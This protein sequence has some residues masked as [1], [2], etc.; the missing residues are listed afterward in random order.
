MPIELPE[1]VSDLRTKIARASLTN[2]FRQ[3]LS[4]DPPDYIMNNAGQIR[5]AERE[6]HEHYAPQIR[7]L[8]QASRSALRCVE[9]PGHEAAVTSFTSSVLTQPELDK[10]MRANLYLEELV[11]GTLRNGDSF[12][13]LLTLFVQLGQ[14]DD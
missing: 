7:L 5:R 13:T 14:L 9:G 3:A 11:V 2:F 8:A 4:E 12:R 10:F 1:D 6:W